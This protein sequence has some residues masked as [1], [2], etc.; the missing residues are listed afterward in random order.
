MIPRLIHQIYLTG[1]LP[2]RLQ[3][4][5]ADL[6]A[7]QP[8]WTHRLYRNADAEDFILRHYGREM[9]GTYHRIN[10]EYGAARADLL[11]QL[12]IFIEGGVYID[13]KSDLLKP[14]DEVIGPSDQYILTQ[15]RNGP[16]EVNE[17]FGLHPE[18]S[19]IPGGEFTNH[20]LIG[21][22]GHSFTEAAIKRIVSNIE[23]YRP[24]SGVGKMGVVR[25]TGPVAYTLALHP[26]LNSAPHR[27]STEEELGILFSIKDYSH[28]A[29]FSRHYSTLTSPVVRLSAPERLAQA[30]VEWLRGL[31]QA[32]LG[33]RNG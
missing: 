26:L 20:H 27:L 28:Q 9:L 4:H 3:Q 23:N 8:N 18:L 5:V 32:H 2:T 15:W 6:R 16:G 11:R 17:G 31:K 12:I 1:E 25:T 29:V 22:P 19:H 30:G 14:L 33:H 10:P 13:I 21:V 24:W 7:R